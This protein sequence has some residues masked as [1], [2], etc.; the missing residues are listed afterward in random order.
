[1]IGIADLLKQ[2]KLKGNIWYAEELELIT[3]EKGL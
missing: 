1:M 3:V 2:S